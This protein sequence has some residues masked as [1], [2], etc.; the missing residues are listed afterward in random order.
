MSAMSDLFLLRTDRVVTP[1]P[2]NS[3]EQLQKKEKKSSEMDTAT[4]YNLSNGKM[5]QLWQ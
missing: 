4:I 5:A 3:L 2:Q 1:H